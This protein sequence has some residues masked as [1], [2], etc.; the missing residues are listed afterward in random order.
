VGSIPGDQMQVSKRAAKGAAYLSGRSLK[1]QAT[2]RPSVESCDAESKNPDSEVGT[3]PPSAPRS[4]ERGGMTKKQLLLD[5]F[6]FF[7]SNTEVLPGNADL[8]RVIQTAPL[9]VIGVYA[10]NDVQSAKSSSVTERH[11]AGFLA[12]TF[13]FTMTPA[14]LL[15]KLNC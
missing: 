2:K 3:E 7:C 10:A 4:I 12:H 6:R 13:P 15:A 11:H 5:T 14:R 8:I 1:V 9:P